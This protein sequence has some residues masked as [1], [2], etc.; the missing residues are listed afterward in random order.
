LK[1]GFNLGRK[2]TP[3]KLSTLLCFPEELEERNRRKGFIEDE[4]YSKLTAAA[5]ELWFRAILGSGHRLRL[6]QG[7]NS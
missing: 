6:A 1:R 7:P 2:A 4:Q 3:P 5:T